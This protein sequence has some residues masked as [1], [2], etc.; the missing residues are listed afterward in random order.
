[1]ASL[2]A[3]R[4]PNAYC[5]IAGCRYKETHSSIH[6]FCGR[7]RTFGHGMVECGSDSSILRLKRNPDYDSPLPRNRWCTVEGCDNRMFHITSSHVC[8]HCSGRGGYHNTGCPLFAPTIQ[9]PT[10]KAESI[11][12][13]GSLLYT[14]ADCIICLEAGPVVAFKPCGHANVCSSCAR[15]LSGTGTA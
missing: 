11:A 15:R 13:F 6:H 10:C 5:R 9:C 3:P 14:G 1:M 7:C 8:I 2:F 4:S 12:D